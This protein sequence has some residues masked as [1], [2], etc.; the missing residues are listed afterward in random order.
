MKILLLTL[1]ISVISF[2][3]VRSANLTANEKRLVGTW[4]ANGSKTMYLPTGKF[5]SIF[6]PNHMIIST[7]V[8][9]I[10]GNKLL[11]ITMLPTRP[12]PRILNRFELNIV[13][14][15]KYELIVSHKGK[16]VTKSIRK[17]TSP[18]G[19]MT[20]PTKES[21]RKEFKKVGLKWD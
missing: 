13:K 8:W 20:K 12:K 3:D 6:N 7:G 14:L 17:N 10:K 16:K 5:I 2:T 15:G 4:Y 1:L 19:R 21:L 9:Y 18:P 11:M